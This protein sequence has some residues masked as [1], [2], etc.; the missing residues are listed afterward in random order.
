MI[1]SKQLERRQLVLIVDDYEINRD[2]LEVIL[3][4]DYDVIQAENGKEALKQMQEH[5]NDLSLVMLDL[6]M[7][8]MSGF[9]VMEEMRKDEQLSKLP[10]I[11]LTAEKEAEL[12][13]LQLGAYD[14]ITKPFDQPEIIKARVSRIIE[15]SEGRQLISTA[16]HDRLTGLYTRNFFVEYARRLFKYH[17]EMKLAAIVVNVEQFHTVNALHGREFG[18]EVLRVIG[19]EIGRFLTETEGIACRFESDSFGIFCVEQQDYRILLDRIQ[20]RVNSISER[21]SLH[22]RMG[23]K[24][25][26]EGVKPVLQFDQARAACNKVRGSY[27]NPLMIYGVEMME[28]ELLDQRLFN[29]LR[30]AVDD[31]Q[32]KVYFQPKYNIQCDPPRLSSAEAL[33]RWIHP[34]LGF[35]RPDEFVSLFEGNGVIGTVDH[36][37]WDETAKQIREWRDEYGITVPVSV[38]LSRSEVFDPDLKDRF[39]RLIEDNGLTYDDLKIELTESAYAENISQLFEIINSLRAMGFEVEMDDFGSGYSSLNMLSDM[40]FDVLKMDM[41]FIR[42]IENSE[43]DRRLIKLVLDIAKYLKVEVVAEGVETEFQMRFL[44]EN[45]CD[46]IQGYYFSKPLPPDEFRALIEK[47]LTIERKDRR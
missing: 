7:P 18:D 14:F 42:N 32:F 13:A 6:I 24:P 10:V 1:K 38:N 34:D 31:R 27:Q 23:V 43:T 46:L 12:T 28:R 19:G 26:Q 33:I 17:P 29:D 3:E 44:K 16:E 35:I 8:V 36:F 5:V 21:V 30:G 25:W 37:V 45:G 11:V 22:L 4:D 2:A 40:P 47:E 9:E 39:H 15:L 20:D 41:K